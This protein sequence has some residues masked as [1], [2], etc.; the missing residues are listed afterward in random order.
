MSLI[1]DN[2]DIIAALQRTSNKAKAQ[3]R[4]YFEIIK[5]CVAMH[6][7][8]RSAKNYE[9]SDEL[10]GILNS[11]GVRIVQGTAQFGSYENIPE[12]MRNTLWDDTWEFTDYSQF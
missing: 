12:N 4:I 10:R 7:K 3:Q 6:Q 9:V 5:Q 8:Y 2:D 11:V 1:Q